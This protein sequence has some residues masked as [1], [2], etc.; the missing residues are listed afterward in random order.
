MSVPD[1]GITWYWEH[2][3]MLGDPEY[4]NKWQ[5]KLDWYRKNNIILDEKGGG[6]KRQVAYIT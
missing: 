2:L 4:D 3:G 1:T 6:G 5:A